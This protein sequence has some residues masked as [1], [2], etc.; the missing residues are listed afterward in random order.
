MNY[1]QVISIDFS[2]ALSM[3]GVVGTITANDVSEKVNHIGTYIKDERIFYST[4]VTSQ[5]QIVAALVAV[6]QIT[7]QKAATKVK[8]FI[9]TFIFYT[10]E[11]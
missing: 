3:E 4:E 5:G 7:A 9:R 8:V 1:L 10:E 6:D 2:D 11:F